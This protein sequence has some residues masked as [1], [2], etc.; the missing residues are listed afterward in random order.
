MIIYWLQWVGGVC[1]SVCECQLCRECSRKEHLNRLPS[2]PHPATATAPLPP[3][4][5]QQ[6]R[7]WKWDRQQRQSLI[8]VL[9]EINK[10][11]ISHFLLGILPS[12]HWMT[13]WLLSWNL[14]GWLDGWREYQVVYVAGSHIV[15]G[16]RVLF[17]HI[18]NDI[19]AS[20]SWYRGGSA[21]DT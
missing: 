11:Y 1:L 6:Q 17:K 13:G 4:H 20:L 7:R 2:T 12:H 18:W 14:C 16:I 3:Y 21:G 19:G 9:G 5:H 8:S 15:A 10:I